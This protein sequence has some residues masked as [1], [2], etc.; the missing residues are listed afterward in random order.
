MTA[1]QNYVFSVICVLLITFRE[2]K[3]VVHG[4]FSS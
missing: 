3:S 2:K 1:H 4:K